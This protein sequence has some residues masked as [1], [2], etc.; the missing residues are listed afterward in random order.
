MTDRQLEK[1]HN[2]IIGV[3]NLGGIV[4]IGIGP[5]SEHRYL[6]ASVSMKQIELL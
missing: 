5:H 6:N 2:A 3:K 4:M 1:I